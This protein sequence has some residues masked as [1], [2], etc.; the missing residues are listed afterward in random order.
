MDFTTNLIEEIRL[1]IGRLLIAHELYKLLP[2]SDYE[3]IKH[4][5]NKKW[6]DFGTN[7]NVRDFWNLVDS[8]MM[9]YK[10]KNITRMITSRGFDWSEE[11]LETADL[12]FASDITKIADF[13]INGKTAREVSLYLQQH[14]ADY[15]TTKRKVSN[16]Y[17]PSSLRANDQIIVERHA[18]NTFHVHDGNGRLLKAIV[19]GTEK[20]TCFLCVPNNFSPNTDCWIA[21]A[22][23]MRLKDD[24]IDVS[25]ILQ[26]S[27]NARF[28]YGDRVR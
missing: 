11:L 1:K 20:L 21:T 22:Y 5:V 18:N 25:P 10:L 23:L 16:E 7:N 17:T 3:Q 14:P 8:L 19:D 24:G 9:G 15:E 12:R 27:Q 13:P 26:Q 28:E 6:S 2:E 4:Q